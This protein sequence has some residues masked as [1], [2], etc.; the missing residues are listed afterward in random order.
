M[1]KVV[2]HKDPSCAAFLTF[3]PVVKRCQCEYCDNK[4]TEADLAKV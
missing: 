4:Y 2:D 1:N 3:I